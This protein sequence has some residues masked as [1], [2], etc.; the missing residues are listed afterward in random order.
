MEDLNF[1][2]YKS[3]FPETPSM[4]QQKFKKTSFAKMTIVCQS[5]KLHCM[6]ASTNSDLSVKSSSKWQA[7]FLRCN[8]QP[9]CNI[10]EKI[11]EYQLI[12]CPIRLSIHMVVI[13]F[14]ISVFSLRIIKDHKGNLYGGINMGKK[15]I[16]INISYLGCI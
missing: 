15:L 14:S 11:T 2:R 3:D 10:K 9:I 4:I 1:R 13:S 6:L 16:S 7:K 8:Q 5:S 12:E